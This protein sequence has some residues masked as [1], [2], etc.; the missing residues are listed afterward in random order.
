MHWLCTTIDVTSEGTAYRYGVIGFRLA[1]RPALILHH[2]T[3]LET[4]R[5][6]RQL[7]QGLH[8]L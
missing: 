7:S 5:T 1:I 3:L 2:W 8:S 6:A 4:A